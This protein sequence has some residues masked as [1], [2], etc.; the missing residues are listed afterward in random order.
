MIQFID[1]IYK[2]I[3]ECQ[4]SAIN[5][6]KYFPDFNICDKY[7]QYEY[8]NKNLNEK[9]ELCVANNDISFDIFTYATNQPIDS[10]SFK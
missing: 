10:I 4:K 8:A 5:L 1:D 2:I 3:N 7:S 9:V 6:K